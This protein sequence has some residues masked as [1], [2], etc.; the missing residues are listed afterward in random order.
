MSSDRSTCWIFGSTGNPLISRAPVA[1]TPPPM[2]SAGIRT[3]SKDRY[4]GFA[5]GLEA[6]CDRNAAK[7]EDG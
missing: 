2:P 7:S 3:R 5:S 4:T 1:P 6:W